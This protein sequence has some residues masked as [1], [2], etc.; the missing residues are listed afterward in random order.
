M[1][2]LRELG[3]TDLVVDEIYPTVKNNFNIFAVLAKSDSA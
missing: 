2:E 1:K 3:L